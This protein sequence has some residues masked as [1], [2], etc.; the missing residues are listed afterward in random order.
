[1]SL[2]T[3]GRH[4]DGVFT[5]CREVRSLCLYQLWGG[6]VTLSLPTMWRYGHGVFTNCREVK[7]EEPIIS[8]TF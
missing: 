1:M 4:G 3:V 6:T 2:P 7:R 8:R 5:N